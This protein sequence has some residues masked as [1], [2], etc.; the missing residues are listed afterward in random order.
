VSRG[1][2][3]RRAAAFD[4]GPLAAL[5]S[6]CFTHPWTAS[7]I[8]DE[9]EGVER[10]LVLVLEGRRAPGDPLAGIRAYASFRLVLDEVHVMNVAVAPAHRR[11]G[12]ARFLLRFALG[13]AVRE[14]AARAL[15]EVRAG[16]REALALYA[17]V[18]F[19]PCG[20]R[21]DYYRDPVEDAVVLSLEAVGGGVPPGR[22]AEP[23]PDP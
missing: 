8:A 18:G 19:V 10:G 2:F 9:V 22:A 23:G 13:R 16:N 21:R 15:L 3:L 7:Q 12:L 4:V 17:A 20:R 6:A 1:V 14:G 11:R 5:E